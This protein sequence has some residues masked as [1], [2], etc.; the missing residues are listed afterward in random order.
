M[1]SEFYSCGKLLITGEYLVLS[2]A[3]AF[4]VPTRK[5]QWMKVE[6]VPGSGTI[7]WIARQPDQKVWLDMRLQISGEIVL[8][9][10]AKA[11]SIHIQQILQTINRLNPQLFKNNLDYN[12]ETRLEFP[13][14]WGLGSSSSMLA[15]LAKWSKTDPMQLFR[16]TLMGSGYDVAVAM[17]G[18]PVMYRLNQG[19]PEWNTLTFQ[20]PFLNTLFFVYSGQ[21]QNSSAEV[22]RFLDKA[23]PS[24]QQ[25]E[26]ISDIS[27]SIMQTKH[28]ETFAMLL[29]RHEEIV[30]KVLGR[31]PVQKIRF[32]DFS[33]TVKSLGAWGGDFFLAIGADAPAYFRSRGYPVVIPWEDMVEGP[34]TF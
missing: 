25:I 11:E 20:P 33:G 17:E 7:H 32:S 26:A 24:R 30:S 31:E 8:L 21:K 6:E 12:I 27:R 28:P 10:E 9:S 34:A 18:K 2:G 22:G 3:W 16:N 1:Q 4:S 14:E 15:N 23:A 5:G 13:S 29:R 19:K